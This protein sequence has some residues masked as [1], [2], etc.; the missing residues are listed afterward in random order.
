MIGKTVSHYRILEKLGEGGMGVVYRAEDTKLKREVAIKFLPRHI[1]ASDEERNRFKIEAQA[2]AALNHIN[3]ATIHTI[4]ETDEELFIVMEYIEG[5]ELSELVA[6]TYANAPLQIDDICNYAIQIAEGM[7]AAHKKAIVH[8]DIKSSN[9]MITDKGQ[10]KIMDFGLAKVLGGIKVTKAGTTLGTTTYMSPEQCQGKEV[11]HRTDI[12]SFGVILYEMLTGQLPFNGDYEQA[13]IYS[14]LNEDPKSIMEFRE[15]TSPRLTHIV[16]KSLQKNPIDRYQTTE[17]LIE[18]LKAIDKS[19]PS[20]QEQQSV[21]TVAVLPFANMSADKEQEY[22]C[23]GIAEDILNDLTQLEGLHVVARTSSFAIKGKDQDI[24]EIGRKLGAHTIVE[25][26]VRKAE[27]RLRIT[28]KLV[29][30]ADGYH[31][32]SE[33]Y[34]RELEDVFAIQ[35][36][37]AKSIVQ[38]LKIKLSNR[39]KRA[40]GKAKTQDVQAYDFYLRG[41]TFFHQGRRKS[42]EYACEMFTRAI[43]EDPGYTLAYAGLADCYSYLFMYFE[44]G[45]E[46]IERSAAASKKALGLDPELAEAHA[47]RGLAVSLDGQYDEAE[48]EFDKAIEFNPKLYEA[49]YFYARTCRQQGKIEKAVQLFEKAGEVRPEDYQAPLFVASAYRKL[50]LP[51]KSEAA[52]RRALELADKHLQLNPDDARALYLGAGALTE[53]GEVEKAIEWGKRAIAIDPGDPRVLY[54]VACIYSLTGKIEPALDYFEKAIELG[55]ASREWIDN[56]Q[57]LDPIRDHPRFQEALKKLN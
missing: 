55:Y 46:N 19:E 39:E 57:D 17:D 9:I 32:W 8:R 47:A 2:A 51:E 5:K 25:G 35:D 48:K 44:K 29:N 38:T 21:P 36:E 24:R 28:V 14:I 27:N 54:N 40:L 13:V 43:K 42:I 56:D 1:A 34:D 4:E 50:K 49:Y 53:L 30:V 33:R 26:S 7:Q 41:R 15:N 18:E 3:I 6:A 11:D 20:V 37:I 12:W 31:L 16:E 22:F 45:R 52:H 23:D 10:G